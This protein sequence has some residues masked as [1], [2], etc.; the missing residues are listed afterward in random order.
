M[1]ISVSFAIIACWTG[2]G[3]APR[4]SVKLIQGICITPERATCSPE[5]MAFRSHRLL[6]RGGVD[7]QLSQPLASCRK[8]RVGD[9]GSDAPA[10]GLAHFARR[11]GALHNVD[12]DLDGLSQ[13]H[14][15]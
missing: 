13:A 15:L 12:L 8:D 6:Q 10:R 11:M 1:R 14:Q 3:S 2:F 5:Q 4:R 7:R 9:S